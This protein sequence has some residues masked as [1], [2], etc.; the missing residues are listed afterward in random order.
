MFA[1]V[2]GVVGAINIPLI[3]VSVLWFRSLHPESVVARPEGPALPP[4][5][6]VTMLTAVLAWTVLLFSLMLLRYGAA[7]L[8]ARAEARALE[9]GATA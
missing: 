5:M 8:E 3:H 7:R 2:I 6:L 1:A 4:D 9:R